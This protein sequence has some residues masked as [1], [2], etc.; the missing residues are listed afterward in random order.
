MKQLDTLK[1]IL[2]ECEKYKSAAL[3]FEVDGETLCPAKAMEDEAQI[4]VFLENQAYRLRKSSEYTDNLLYA[5][6]H[7]DML[8]GYDRIMV[9]SLYRMFEKEK[10]ISPEKAGELSLLQKKAYISWCSAYEKS[11]FSLFRDDLSALVRS[12]QE[13]I[14][15]CSGTCWCFC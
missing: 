10:N 8:T 14:P 7:R 1:D 2:R 3:L 11:D 13:I 15:R 6:E 4:G 9:D 5:H 12:K